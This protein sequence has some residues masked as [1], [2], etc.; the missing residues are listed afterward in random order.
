MI[1]TRRVTLGAGYRYLMESVAVGD[2]GVSRPESLA[3]YY[4]A[5]GTPPGRFLGSGLAH[6]G[7][8]SGVVSGSAVSEE[9]L[10]RMLGLCADPLTGM[11]VGRAPNVSS[12][13]AAVAGFDLTFSP[14][15]SISVAWALADADTRQVIYDCHRQAIDIVLAYAERTVFRSRSGTDGIVEE[16]IDGIIAAAFTHFDS[17][18]GD[19][20]LHDHVIVWNRA[21]STSDGRWRTLD[22]RAIFQARSALSSMHQGVLSDLLTDRLGVGWDARTRRH[23]DRPRW[24]IT[25]IPEELMAEFSTRSDHIETAKDNLIERFVADHGRRPTGVEIIRLRQQATLATRPAKTQRSL[26]EMTDAWHHQATPHLP[27]PDSPDAHAVE[28]W[29][30]L[31]RDRNTLPLL[32]EGDLDAAM[33]GDAAA[34]VVD[35]VAEKQATFR[36]DNL[37]DEAHRLLAGVRFATPAARIAAAEQVTDLAVERSL[38]LTPPELVHT[39]DR[40]LRHDGT[41]RLRPQS[42][43]RYTTRAVLDAEARLLDAAHQTGAPTATADTAVRPGGVRLSEDQATAVTRIVTSGRRLDVLVG[44][45]GTGKT[46]AMAALA[47]VWEAEHGPGSVIGL[48]PSAAAAEV[49]AGELQTGTE[50]TAKWLTEHHRRPNRGRQ[51]D[52]LTRALDTHP[53][54]GSASAA[55]LRDRLGQ[56]DQD[57]HRW[58]LRKGQLV[59]IDEASLASTT[60]LD[61]LVTAATDAGAKILLVGDWAQ[62]SAVDA[63]G[64][65]GLLAHD[66]VASVVELGT[67]RRFTHDWERAA[68]IDLR[69]GLEGAFDAYQTHQRITD[70]TRD[71]LLDQLYAAWKTDTDAGHTSLMI[72]ADRGTVDELN[73]RAQT[74]RIAAG[75]VSQ[76]GLTVGEVTFG[77]GD[78]VV[79]RRND[80]R[81]ITGAGWVKNGDRWTVTAIKTDGRVTVRRAGGHSTV[82]L[83]ADY[84]GQHLELGYATTA[85]RAQGRTVETAH[86]LINATTSREVLYVAGT[87]G[88]HG[89][90]L[91]VDTSYDPEPTTSHGQPAPQNARSVFAAVLANRGAELSAHETVRQA[92]RD[93]ESWATLH[94]EYQTIA[95][96]AQTDRWNTLLAQTPLTTAQHE[97]VTA[98]PALG[99]LH[100]ALRNAEAHGI[101]LDTTLPLVVAARPLQSADDIAAVIG[102]RL[103]RLT[104]AT[105]TSRRAPAADL[106]AGL[107]PRARNIADPDLARALQERDHALQKRAFDLAGDAITNRAPWLNRLGR[108]SANPTAQRRWVHAVATIAAYRDRWNIT[109]QQQPFGSQ[110]PV[111]VEQAQQRTRATQAAQQAIRINQTSRPQPSQP[112]LEVGIAGPAHTRGVDL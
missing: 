97:S 78:L 76:T 21:R 75:Q 60:T 37:L 104:H 65:F 85:H 61:Q 33:L 18:A 72:A 96:A 58:E 111:S 94:A 56:L 30:G 108:P 47:K 54:P 103:E 53:Y 16:D 9:H 12:K 2:G 46:T 43:L 80:R 10:Y 41:S 86:A 106:I 26:A 91:Y 28:N 35:T 42:R 49:L 87:R 112:A 93:V 99:A 24:E 45:A 15:K 101:D 83:P 23:S 8:G 20:Q 100:A 34:V 13:A 95:Q 29:V 64:A 89:N 27:R 32:R 51:R 81:L 74:D 68:S 82:T 69:N 105:S 90:H 22:S 50:N 79:T 109:D 48:A 102:A 67:V 84:V 38:N 62:L 59:I 70:G 88:R 63:G 98:S 6:I 36:R 110:P 5:S 107:V 1:S 25:G 73:R 31:W 39:P 19:P 4:A 7:D 55:G 52:R 57:I 11:P 92:Q 77:V 3:A 44:P 14:S 71:Q 17:R 66:P 40:Y